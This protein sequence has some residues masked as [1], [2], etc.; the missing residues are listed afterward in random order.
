DAMGIPYVQASSEGEAQ[1]AFMS[2]EK[3]VY[4]VGSQDWDCLLFGTDTMV[5]NL[6]SRKTRKTSAGKRK[7]VNQERIE[8]ENVLEELNLSREQLVMLGMLMGT[9]F[10]DGVH[11]IGP[12]KG[13]EKAREHESLQSLLGDEDI[14]FKS[15]NPPEAIFDFFMNPPVEKSDFSFDSPSEEK[16]KDILV[17]QH[18]FSSDRIDSKLKD[19]EK[20]M[21]S[22]QS[23]LGSFT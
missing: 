11:G 10:N 21:E 7:K 9:D 6:T 22:R 19:L 20:A 3:E 12:K 2:A 14:E 13:L 15:D 1:A 23:G 5:R 17:D 18:D 8:L 16:I 4:A